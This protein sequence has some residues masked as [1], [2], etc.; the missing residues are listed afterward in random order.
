VP[1][2]ITG[3]RGNLSYRPDLGGAA[4]GLVQEPGKAL[5]TLKNRGLGATGLLKDLLEK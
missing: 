3:P 5:D 4:K 1:V 2:A